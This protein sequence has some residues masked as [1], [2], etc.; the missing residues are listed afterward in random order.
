MENQDLNIW[1]DRAEFHLCKSGNELYI[2]E[3]IDKKNKV[4]NEEGGFCHI[5]LGNTCVN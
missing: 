3:D 2:N 5:A 1:R 4:V